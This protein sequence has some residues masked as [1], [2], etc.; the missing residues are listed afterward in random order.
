MLL[1]LRGSDARGDQA[2]QEG[3]HNDQ[4]ELIRHLVHNDH[5]HSARVEQV[6]QRG[7]VIREHRVALIRGKLLPECSSGFRCVGS[8]EVPVGLDALDQ[9]REG[10]RGGSLEDLV[11]FMPTFQGDFDE[12]VV[13]ELSHPVLVDVEAEEIAPVFGG[14]VRTPDRELL[15]SRRCAV[16]GTAFRNPDCHVERLGLDCPTPA[17]GEL[18]LDSFLLAPLVEGYVNPLE[19]A[20]GVEEQ[21]RL[22]ARVFADG[23]GGLTRAQ[24]FQECAQG[25]GLAGT[26][27]AEQSDHVRHGRVEMDIGQRPRLS[28]AAKIDPTRRRVAMHPEL[29]R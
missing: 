28:Q 29:G 23:R 19:D 16:R 13:Q 22:R 25:V 8:Q 5:A 15:M 4:T 1:R 14:E 11:A 3:R 20:E 27:L 6:L 2:T 18:L 24:P 26:A 12:G 17:C 10:I 21:D 7:S 9:G